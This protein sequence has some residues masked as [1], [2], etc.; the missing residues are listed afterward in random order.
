[1]T[2]AHQTAH[3][4]PIA[5]QFG[6]LVLGFRRSN[7]GFAVTSGS[8]LHVSPAAAGTVDYRGEWGF[9][10]ARFHVDVSG[11][12]VALARLAVRPT[13]ARGPGQ[14]HVLLRAAFLTGCIRLHPAIRSI[15]DPP[16][17]PSVLI[18]GRCSLRRWTKRPASQSPCARRPPSTS[19]ARKS[20]PCASAACWPDAKSSSTRS[21][22][23]F[24]WHGTPS[25]R[26]SSR[27]TRPA[28]WRLRS[29]WASKT[30][31][32]GHRSDGDGG[33][34]MP[35]LRPGRSVALP[36]RRTTDIRRTGIP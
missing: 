6:Q 2:L 8:R 11:S 27:P 35:P 32:A 29:A 15:G 7:G 25:K 30:R 5:D 24:S 34:G 4:D 23:G 16:L 17:R 10:A 14:R 3:S 31:Y 13:S 26:S 18:T 21:P 1:M 9:R 12:Y 20:S 28:S 22:T 36:D 33:M 19:P